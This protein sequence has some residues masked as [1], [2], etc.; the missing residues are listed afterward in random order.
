MP[1][2][3]WHDRSFPVQ[4]DLISHTPSPLA[5]HNELIRAIRT[6]VRLFQMAALGVM[7]M[8]KHT[9]GKT[10]VGAAIEAWFGAACAICKKHAKRRCR[11]CAMSFCSSACQIKAIKDG[12]AEK[13][14]TASAKHGQ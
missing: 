13:C 5:R 2:L 10:Q 12:H 1:T 3:L 9:H 7:T 4:A 11:V 14:H 6:H 8:P